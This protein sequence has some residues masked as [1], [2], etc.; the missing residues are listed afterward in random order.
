VLVADVTAGSPAAAVGIQPG[1]LIVHFH[2]RDINRLR[3]LPIQIAQ[4]P[5]GSRVDITVLRH[6]Q[7][8]TVQA[9]IAELPQRQRRAWQGIEPDWPEAPWTSRPDSTSGT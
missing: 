6:G 9:T 4:T 1:D 5:V 8:R 3:D 2:N 7:E